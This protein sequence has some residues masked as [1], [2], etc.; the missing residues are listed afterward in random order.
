MPTP[1]Y[2]E[3]SNM[4]GYVSSQEIL[5]V[6]PLTRIDEVEPRTVSHS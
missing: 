6:R 4:A 3:L 5:R 2:V 1:F